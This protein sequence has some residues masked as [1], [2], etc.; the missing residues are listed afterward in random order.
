MLTQFGM[1]AYNDSTEQLRKVLMSLCPTAYFCRKKLIGDLLIVVASIQVTEV[2]FFDEKCFYRQKYCM[3]ADAF[4][5]PD[6]CAVCDDIVCSKIS[7]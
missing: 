2:M 1:G 7:D 4:L 6:T 5:F 3:H